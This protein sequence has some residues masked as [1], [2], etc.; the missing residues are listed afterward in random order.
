[1]SAENEP[2]YPGASVTKTQSLLLL[3]CFTIRH[4]LTGVALG[5]LLLLLN[6]LLPNIVPAT[7]YRFYKSLQLEQ[8]EV[9]YMSQLLV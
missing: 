5:D 4:K 8:S 1:M 3:L 6:A 7:K 2:I 9:M